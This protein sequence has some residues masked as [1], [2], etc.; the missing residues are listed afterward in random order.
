MQASSPSVGNPPRT[1]RSVNILTPGGPLQRTVLSG[2]NEEAHAQ[3]LLRCCG[4]VLRGNRS[5][6]FEVCATLR[7]PPEVRGVRASES[8]SRNL[9]KRAAAFLCILSAGKDLQERLR[10]LRSGRIQAL[11]RP[12]ATSL[13]K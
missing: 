9:V 12:G 3:P 13:T 1:I 11:L 7:R 8:G 6:R 10:L 4:C 2:N 5:S